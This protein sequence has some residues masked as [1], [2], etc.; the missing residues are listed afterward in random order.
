MPGAELIVCGGQYPDFQKLF[1]RWRNLFIHKQGLPHAELSKLMQ[2]CTAFVF[3]SIEEGFARVI[4]EAMA[5]GLPIIATHNSGASTVV[6]NGK[7][8]FIV[9]A[10]SADAV[11]ERMKEL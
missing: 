7:E 3:P 9:P 1:C 6:E 11:Y 8:G 5:C 2:S 4:A 10:R